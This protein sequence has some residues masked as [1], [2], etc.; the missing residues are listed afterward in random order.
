MD[1][2]DRA[3]MGFRLSEARSI[4]RSFFRAPIVPPKQMR[5]QASHLHSNR[6]R[7]LNPNKKL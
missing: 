3:R 7:Q 1:A 4:K 2:D 5:F 6:N